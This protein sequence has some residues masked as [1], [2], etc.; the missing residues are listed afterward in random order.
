M[1][2]RHDLLETLS[3]KKRQC[4]LLLGYVAL[5]LFGAYYFS[6]YWSAYKLMKAFEAQDI[7]KIKKDIPD[8]LLSH[9]FPKMHSAQHWH[10]A[11]HKYLQ[12]VESRLYSETNRDAWLAIQAQMQILKN[13][14]YYYNHFFNHYRLDLGSDNSHDQIRI[15]FQRSYFM[16]W[17][18]TRVC[19]P[20]P[21]A[22]WVENRCPSSK[23]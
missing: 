4:W 14:H 3:Q 11:G 1:S 15:E 13:T 23:R 7:L 20:N 17:N 18:I 2:I 16:S 9:F 21:Q 22:D 19:Y 8:K 5:L 6:P 12:H 10:G